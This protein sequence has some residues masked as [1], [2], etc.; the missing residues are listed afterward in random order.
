L[1]DDDDDDYDYNYDE[2]SSKKINKVVIK[3]SARRVTQ[4]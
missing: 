4:T 1:K 3:D 2:M